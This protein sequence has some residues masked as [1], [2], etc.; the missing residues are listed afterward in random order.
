[1]RAQE[2]ASD[3]L[4]AQYRKNGNISKREGYRCMGEEAGGQGMATYN[5][6]DNTDGTVDKKTEAIFARLTSK[7][8]NCCT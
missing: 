5:R 2:Y 1:M 3:M 8:G 6:I 7:S 4:N